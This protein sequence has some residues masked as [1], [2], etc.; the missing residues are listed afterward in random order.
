MTW[1]EQTKASKRKSLV[2]DLHGDEVTSICFAVERESVLIVI[3]YLV[4]NRVCGIV[5]GVSMGSE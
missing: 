4:G 5:T 1:H 3:K 2:L